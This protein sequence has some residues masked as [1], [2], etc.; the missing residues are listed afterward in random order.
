MVNIPE[1][2]AMRLK[3]SMSGFEVGNVKG[4]ENK[5]RPY[6]LFFV[7]TISDTTPL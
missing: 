6:G 3:K 7:L 1:I 5:K 2:P 4:T